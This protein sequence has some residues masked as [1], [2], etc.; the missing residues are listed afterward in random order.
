MAK[1]TEAIHKGKA[2]SIIYVSLSSGE[3]TGE[4]VPHT[5]VDNG[6]GWHVRGYDRARSRFADFVVNRI[7]APQLLSEE[8]PEE[9]TKAADNQWNRIVDLR[10]VAHPRLKH[11]ET[12]ELEYGM[13]DGALK[14]QTRAAVAGYVLRH[15]NV[16]CSKQHSLNGPEYHL[17]LQNTPTLYGVDNLQLAAG[18]EPEP[19]EIN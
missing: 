4:I 16:D 13:Q 3:T 18:Y 6:L 14:V 10:I 15:W 19:S 2:L 5:L 12:I 17:W 11:P 7:E 1:V 8:I 9:Q